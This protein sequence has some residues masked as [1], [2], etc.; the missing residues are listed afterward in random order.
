GADISTFLKQWNEMGMKDKIPFA[1]IG[2]ADADIWGI[3]AKAA[4]GVYAKIWYYDNPENLQEDKDFAATYA[5]KYG[6]PAPD[7]AWMGWY[8]MRPL[9]QALDAAESTE[10]ADVVQALEAWKDEG[11]GTSFRAWDHQMLNPIV[12]AEAKPEVTDEW[13]FLNVL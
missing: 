11:R 13:S 9:L 3:G 2:V 5:E 12:I 8:S 6:R 1:Q 7:R 4:A 10:P